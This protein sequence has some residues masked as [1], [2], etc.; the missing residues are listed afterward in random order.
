MDRNPFEI[1]KATDFT[2]RQI[3]DYWVD[4]IGEGELE[5]LLSPKSPMPLFVLGSKGSGKTHL[6]RYCSYKVR[7]L[8]WAVD[9]RT[10]VNRDGYIGI[11]VQ[12][13]GLNASR[14]SG[15]GIAPEIW[16]TLFPYAFE[17]WTMQLVLDVVLDLL[18]AP[19]DLH[20]ESQV[21]EEVCALFDRP[22]A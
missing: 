8:G 21:V 11:Y 15:R 6:L 13:D 3:R 2:D 9:P 18:G 20:R 7:R 14:F 5:T 22:P 10:G 17:L 19:G 16:K 12:A 4:L 1:T